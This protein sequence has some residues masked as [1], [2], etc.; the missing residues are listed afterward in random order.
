[1]IEENNF[2]SV[3]VILNTG[4]RTTLYDEHYGMELFDL[5]IFN[6]T[7]GRTNILLYFNIKIRSISPQFVKGLCNH[8]IH[9][10]GVEWIK[11]CVHVYPLKLEE[12]FYAGL[13]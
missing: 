12:Q 2:G 4:N 6:K 7:V 8:W 9:N 13:V 10:N 1:M 3:E 5:Q 11:E